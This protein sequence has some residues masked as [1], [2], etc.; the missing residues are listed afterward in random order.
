M[1]SDDF[2]SWI[3]FFP[4]MGAWSGFWLFYQFDIGIYDFT[5]WGSWDFS[6]NWFF[7]SERPF[8]GRASSGYWFFFFIIISL[9]WALI[10]SW[11]DRD[12]FWS[13]WYFFWSPFVC[14]F[15]GGD[16]GGWR[17][18]FSNEFFLSKALK[19]MI[20]L[21]GPSG[22]LLSFGLIRE[23]WFCI[24]KN[25]ENFYFSWGFCSLDMIIIS[26]FI[27]YFHPLKKDNWELRITCL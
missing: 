9:I 11:G 14:L 4:F 21:I 2:D 22:F 25:T 23:R 18:W 8:F 24:F 15:F 17:A 6:L 12:I 19:W 27:S 3:P 7:F 5:S 20:S 10:S 26:M 1:G 16:T 13:K